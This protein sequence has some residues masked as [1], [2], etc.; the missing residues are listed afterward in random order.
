MQ[1]NEIVPCPWF[2]NAAEEAARSHAGIFRHSKI[3]KIA[4]YGKAGFAQL[5]R[6]YEGR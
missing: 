5:E 2:A 6:A 3:G 1:F 4:R